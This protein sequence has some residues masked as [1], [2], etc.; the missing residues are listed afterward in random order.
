MR[1]QINAFYM[2]SELAVNNTRWACFM[3]F[4]FITRVEPLFC[5]HRASDSHYRSSRQQAVC[6]T[7]LFPSAH[8]SE[9]YPRWLLPA[10]Q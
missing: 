8:Q 6:A 3:L 10:W 9:G 4:Y 2:E 1:E 5:Q 7:S